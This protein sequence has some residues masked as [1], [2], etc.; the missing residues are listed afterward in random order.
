MYAWL[1]AEISIL[2][3]TF[4]PYLNLLPLWYPAMSV[5]LDVETEDILNYIREDLLDLVP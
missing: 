1:A 4:L 3:T 2:A 5:S